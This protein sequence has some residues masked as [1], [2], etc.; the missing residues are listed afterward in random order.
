MKALTINSLA[1]PLW[2]DAVSN[3]RRLG[4]MIHQPSVTGLH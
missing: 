1:I 4:N 3:N 2:V